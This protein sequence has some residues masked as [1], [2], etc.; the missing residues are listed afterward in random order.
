MCERHK[1]YGRLLIIERFYFAQRNEVSVEEMNTRKSVAVKLGAILSV[2]A[3]MYFLLLGT[4]FVASPTVT[5]SF[6]A[7]TNMWTTSYTYPN[8]PFWMT[9]LIYPLTALALIVT[10]AG[11]VASILVYTRYKAV[12]GQSG[13]PAI[14]ASC[15]IFLLILQR[16]AFTLMGMI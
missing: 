1:A 3:L 7:A 12:L 6:D 13:I 2:Q 16:S 10:V 14:I 8:L 4:T 11:I 5:R 9:S 15:L